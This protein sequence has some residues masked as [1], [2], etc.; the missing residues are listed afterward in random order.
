MNQISHAGSIV[1]RSGRITITRRRNGRFF[2]GLA[3]DEYLALYRLVLRGG[4]QISTLSK[5]SQRHDKRVLDAF[6]GFA[7]KVHAAAG[8]SK[9]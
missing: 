5:E 7:K 8:T 4:Y 1:P 2:V 3:A 9:E 6:T